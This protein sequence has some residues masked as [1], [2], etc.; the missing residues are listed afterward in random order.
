M[1]GIVYIFD[2]VFISEVIL[3]SL[4]VGEV[5]YVGKR[6]NNG[7]KW[8]YILT[9]NDPCTCTRLVLSPSESDGQNSLL[10]DDVTEI[11]KHLGLTTCEGM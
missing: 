10:S 1:L 5:C 6:T 4:V 3:F 9:P 7:R 2:T 11:R 8:R